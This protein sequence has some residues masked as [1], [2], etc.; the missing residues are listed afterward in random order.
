MGPHSSV[1]IANSYELV[2]PGFEFQWWR[3][4]PHVSRTTLGPTINPVKWTP[5]LS[6]GI[7]RPGRGVDHS[8]TFSAEVE[9]RVEL[10]LFSPSGPS[11]PVLGWTLPLPL[12]L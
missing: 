6:G 2:G 4:F 8:P 12:P 7:K 11:C 5:G 9:G 1:G 10:Y 3:D